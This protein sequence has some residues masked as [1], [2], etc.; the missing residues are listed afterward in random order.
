MVQVLSRDIRSTRQRLD[1]GA[2]AQRRNAA[3]LAS[4]AAVLSHTHAEASSSRKSSVTHAD[5]ANGALAEPSSS[6]GT[7]A[8]PSNSA[9]RS[10]GIQGNGTSSHSTVPVTAQQGTGTFHVVLEGVDVSYDIGDQSVDNAV[11]I[12]GASLTT[13]LAMQH[14]HKHRH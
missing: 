1:V 2:A 11:I 10:N 14:K 3:S 5:G 9:G 4:A 8:G 12:G 13:A 6:G 7:H